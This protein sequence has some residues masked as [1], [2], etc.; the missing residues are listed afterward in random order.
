M[1]SSLEQAIADRWRLVEK[2]WEASL[3]STSLR[4]IS[5]SVAALTSA[6]VDIMFSDPDEERVLL[7]EYKPHGCSVDTVPA[8]WEPIGNWTLIRELARVHDA[9]KAGCWNPV[10][11]L[12]KAGV[13]S[14][15]TLEVLP[16]SYC[17][18]EE[19]RPE[20]IPTLEGLHLPAARLQV[21]SSANPQRCA[22]GPFPW[23]LLRVA[24]SR[25][26]AA[27][28][29]S[30][31]LWI[32]DNLRGQLL[33]RRRVVRACV[34]TRAAI[35]PEFSLLLLAV[36]R[37]YGRRSEPDDHVFPAISGWHPRPQGIR[38]SYLGA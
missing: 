11:A 25:E 30:A 10:G 28:R 2:S 12:T 22:A 29:H 26:L 32:I 13:L 9:G 21:R 15:L 23:A 34:L 6:R 33:C 19:L 7:V 27:M 24:I 20:Q 31:K 3:A 16:G 5:E 18:N 36:S 38:G 4:R 8:A 14:G 35:F 17:R 37:R 1:A